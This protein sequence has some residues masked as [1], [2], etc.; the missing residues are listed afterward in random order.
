[1]SS[2]TENSV[3]LTVAGQRHEGWTRIRVTA[4]IDRAARDFEIE[5]TLDWPGRSGLPRPCKVGDSCVVTIGADKVLTG[6]IDATPIRYD[7]NG[8]TLGI[9]GRSKT[10]DL[11]DCSAADSLGQWRDATVE[12]IAAAL[13]KPYG[14]GVRA[15]ADTGD[16]LADHQ[17]QQGE[18]AFES[19][20]RILKA[21][22]LLA[23]DDADGN[24]VFIRPAAKAAT[25]ALILGENILA[26]DYP[27]DG[28][29]RFSH[30]LCKGQS[31]GSDEAFGAAVA[32]ASGAAT[33]PAITRYRL[34]LIQQDGQSDSL[35]CDDRAAYERDLRAAKA[36]A[37]TYTVQ[38]W[39]QGSGALWAPNML[40]RVDD[41]L[42]GIARAMLISEVTYTLDDGGTKT[43]LA[44]L[45]PEA[46]LGAQHRRKA[47][48]KKYV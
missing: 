43:S 9:A 23:T 48:K 3:A 41:R 2:Q 6:F 11:I 14:I 44:L 8:M 45:P 16:A 38:G 40:V 47:K 42:C 34:L 33:D 35:T 39:R 31:A 15:E 30:Y 17:V 10:A 21:R 5:V 20:D 25:T 26:A 22:Q 18:T 13:A 19:I 27:C 7:A 1:M 24:L 32:E 4:G 28:R 37:V 12:Q 36:Q 29:D 46:H